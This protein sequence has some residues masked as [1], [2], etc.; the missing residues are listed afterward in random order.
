VLGLG[1]FPRSTTLTVAIVG[2]GV[3]IEVIAKTWDAVLLGHE[4]LDLVALTTIVQRTTTV[5]AWF[6]MLAL[7]PSLLAASLCFLGG[8]LAGLATDEWAVRRVIGPRPRPD[9]AR[10]WGLARAGVP[11]GLASVLFL[12]LLRVD[13]VLLFFLSGERQVGY[14]AAG[15]RLV[16]S[17][18]FI[19]WAI[20]AAMLPWLV[21]RAAGGLARGYEMALKTSNLVLA[22]ISAGLALFAVPLV[23]RLYGAEF[24]PSVRPVQL[25][26]VTGV[27]YGVQYI[28]ATT[29]VARNEPAR[30]ARLVGAVAAAN[31]VANLLLIP[32]YGADGA[33]G[34]ALVSSAAVAIASSMAARRRF[35][36]IRFWRCSA[37]ALAGVAA[38]AMVR[39]A[40]WPDL[41]EL[42]LAGIAYL[43]T[44][45]T[46]ECLAFG[47]DVR[48]IRR[49]LPSRRRMRASGG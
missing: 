35:G 13:V 39:A 27:L 19:A 40:P 38:M 16:E 26:G 9:P 23:H 15:Y 43:T 3:T 25:I 37:S 12:L 28:A 46:I 11:F 14:Y 31:I 6:A 49:I 4:R 18:Q 8:A 44:V 45:G 5:V 36:R 32:R 24:A 2:L 7:G 21:R 20:G 22:P 10:W 33:A 29:F 1:D 34:V 47:D 48:T 41:V 17:T 30:F 42:G